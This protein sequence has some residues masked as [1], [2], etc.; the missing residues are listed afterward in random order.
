MVS[1]IEKCN[2][3]LEALLGKVT[4]PKGIRAVGTGEFGRGLD[5]YFVA[6]YDPVD[7]PALKELIESV[8]PFPSPR[9]KTAKTHYIVKDNSVRDY[10]LL[11]YEVD[12]WGDGS[13]S[14][15]QHPERY[16]LCEVKLGLL[17]PKR[18]AIAI[19]A[20]KGL[21][22]NP[23]DETLCNFLEKYRRLKYPDPI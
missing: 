14:Q 16:V 6:F 17:G 11:I 8:P 21:N 23:P 10:Q 18:R 2:H 9:I 4:P 22:G 1:G 3:V 13:S 7:V 5:G 15:T 12:E 19:T 20:F